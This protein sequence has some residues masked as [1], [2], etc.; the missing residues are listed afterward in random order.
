MN[1]YLTK[2]GQ[3]LGPYS[4]NQIQAMLA[5]GQ[6]ALT[7]YAWYEG[8]PNWIPLQQV[9]GVNLATT[10]QKRPVLVWIICLLF[11]TC[12][13]FALLSF[14]LMPLFA[15]GAIPT[16]ETHRHFF[17][18][19]NAFDYG[20]GILN[21]LLVLV[22]AVLLF[23]LKRASLYVYAATLVL[24]VFSLIYNIAAKDWLH[25]VGT[26]GTITL[27]ITWGIN[28]LLLYYNWHLCRKGVL[29]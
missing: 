4:L 11:F 29:R 17:Q 18:N 9:P 21:T 13:P 3:Q 10:Q 8:L 27:I 16:D 24:A 15:S 6:A 25:V 23:M 5:S 28:L 1:I 20:L 14:A 19:Q 2:N 22:W 7:D 12:M 26:T